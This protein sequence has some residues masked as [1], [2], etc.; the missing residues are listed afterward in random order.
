MRYAT[1]SGAMK[2]IADRSASSTTSPEPTCWPSTPPSR[3][4]RYVNDHGKASRWS[5][6]KMRKLAERSRVAPGNRRC[7]QQQRATGRAGRVAARRIVPNI[8]RHPTWCRGGSPPR[9]A[10]AEQRRRLNQ[11]RHGPDE[12]D[13][14]AERLGFRG[15]GRHL[16][17]MNAPGGRLLELISFFRFD[18][19]NTASQPLRRRCRSPAHARPP[20]P[21]ASSGHWRRWTQPVRQLQ[22]RARA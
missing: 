3:A 13:H 6:P 15:A 8:R 17:E 11:H 16:R 21:V 7:R 9:L 5:P 14:P 19:T 10:G 12:P 2:Q 22:L 1:W 20:T 4:A 18:A